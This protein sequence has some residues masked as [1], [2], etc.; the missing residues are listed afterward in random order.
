MPVTITWRPSSRDGTVV[1]REPDELVRPYDAA[2]RVTP[3]DQR[4]RRRRSA[5]SRCPGRLVPEPPARRGITPRA[6]SPSSSSWRAPIAECNVGSNT[7]KRRASHRFSRCTSR[8]RHCAAGR[9]PVASRRC[10]R[11]MPTLAVDDSSRAPSRKGDAAVEQS[12]GARPRVLDR[13]VRRPAGTAN[14]SPPMRAPPGPPAG[15]FARCARRQMTG[16]HRLSSWPSVSFTTLKSSRSRNRMM[17]G[18]Q[19]A[20]PSSA[21]P[22]RSA[23]SNG[24]EAR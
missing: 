22:P 4:L 14:P 15:G 18:H 24:W 7:A 5:P 8:C 3:S 12:I 9:R 10:P 11:T 17:G 21:P 6:S 1:L 23:S 13:C 2:H 16:D 19:S 20:A